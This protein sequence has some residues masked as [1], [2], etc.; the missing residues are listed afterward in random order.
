MKAL[1]IH[2]HDAPPVL[3][4]IPRP[5]PGPGEIGVVIRAAAL[6]FADLLMAD[7]RYQDIPPLPATLGLELSGTVETLG[8][9]VTDLSPGD[10]VAI[11]AGQGGLAEY[12]AFPAARAVVLPD[13]M[14]FE[15][16]AAFQIAY[17]TSHLAL[18][19]RARLRPGETLVVLGSS[20]GVGLTAVEL[21]ARM[22]ARV[23]A[24]ARGPEKLSVAARA[25]ASDLIDSGT[26][27]L[28]AALKALGGV[29]VVYD[30]VGG[31]AFRAAL[32]AT[33]PG[34][35]L[36]IIGFASGTVP[37]IRANHLLVKNVD[38][39]GLYWGGYLRFAPEVLKGSLE[40]LFGWYA[41]GGLRPRISHVLPLDRAAEGLDLLRGR[42]ATGKIVITP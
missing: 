25:G 3:E 2:G 28:A 24:V 31:D 8:A 39:I 35:R 37:E 5:S 41:E 19:H 30:A 6:N 20:G 10:R 7:G 1:R 26:G 22:G 12:G 34:G 29:D 42:R 36:L 38:V 21:G 11:F 16:A 4:E 23:V 14:P 32:K 33:R 27:D 40:T 15:D 18:D 13:A 17:G 9:G